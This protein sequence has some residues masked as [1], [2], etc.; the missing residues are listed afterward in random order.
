M[1]SRK[2][3]GKFLGLDSSQLGETGSTCQEI[4]AGINIYRWDERNVAS[5]RK[6]KLAV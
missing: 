2:S 6:E 3:K 1:Q 5:I 4:K